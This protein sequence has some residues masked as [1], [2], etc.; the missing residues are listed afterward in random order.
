MQNF[1][2]IIF[3]IAY[4]YVFELYGAKQGTTDKV[5]FISADTDQKISINRPINRQNLLI[6]NID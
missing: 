1:K 5:F 3:K 4:M 6:G 2:I